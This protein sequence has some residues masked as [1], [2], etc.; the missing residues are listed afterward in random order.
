MSVPSYSSQTMVNH[1]LGE[2]S[3]GFSIYHKLSWNICLPTRQKNGIEIADNET[4]LLPWN[5]AERLVFIDAAF[6]M[7]QSS[8]LMHTNAAPNDFYLSSCLSNGK[9]DIKQYLYYNL[10]N[11]ETHGSVVGYVLWVIS[12]NCSILKELCR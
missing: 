4:L 9:N 1:C 6:L 5:L 10:N 12:I 8:T 2:G 3:I 7:G 11:T